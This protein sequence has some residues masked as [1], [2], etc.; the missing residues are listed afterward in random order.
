MIV[1][2]LRAADIPAKES[3]WPDPPP[4]TYAIYFDAVSTDAPDRVDGVAIVPRIYTHDVTVELYE[5]TADPTSEASVESALDAAGMVWDKQDRY[6]LADVQ[7]YQVVYEF[8]YTD[9]RRM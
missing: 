6:W 3:R 9:K 1:D 5:P 8:S 2:L 7:R 4:V